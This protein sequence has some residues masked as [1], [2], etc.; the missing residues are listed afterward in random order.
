MMAEVKI[1]KEKSYL[2]FPNCNRVFYALLH[3]IVPRASLILAPPGCAS[4][5]LAQFSQLRLGRLPFP[6]ASTTWSHFTATSY[7]SGPG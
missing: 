5:S 2:V 6:G 7:P 3:F 4:P 1:N